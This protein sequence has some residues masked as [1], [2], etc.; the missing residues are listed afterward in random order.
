M[1]L[2]RY[3][4]KRP[5]FNDDI[6]GTGIITLAGVL[7][8]LQISGQKLTDQ[9]YVCFGAGTAG[10]GIANRVMGEFVAQ[11][12]DEEEARCRFYLVDRQGLLFDDMDDLTPEQRPF[13]RKRAEFASGAELATLADVV[14]AVHPTILVGTSTVHGGFTEEVVRE[15]AAHAE[16]PIIFPLSNP[17]KLAEATAADLIRWTEGRGLVATG[18]PSDPVEYDGVTYEIGQANNALIYPGLGLGVLA[19]QARLLTDAMIS[20]AAHSLGG[21]VDTT[22]PGA[23]AIPPVSLLATF[24]NTVAVAVAEQAVADGLNGVSVDDPAAAVT[25][26]RWEPRYE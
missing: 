21:L 26:A 22:K 1:L 12:M 6:E 7:G 4:G 2:S 10:V 14:R 20:R 19:T 17:T 15:M 16:R 11:G 25:A 9:V 24:S 13:A 8:A 18:I 3:I 5:T 23:A